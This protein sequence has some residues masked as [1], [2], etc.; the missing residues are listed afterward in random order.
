MEAGEEGEI[1]EGV[2]AGRGTTEGKRALQVG[3]GRGCGGL[4]RGDAIS[5]RRNRQ[6]A[7]TLK[8]KLVISRC[9]ARVITDFVDQLGTR[10][11]TRVSAC[12]DAVCTNWE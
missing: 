9:I 8:A 3:I 12:H 6:N 1:P 11:D 5:T 2:G 10:C 4:L 7:L